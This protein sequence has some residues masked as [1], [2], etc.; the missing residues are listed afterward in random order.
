[1]NVNKWLSQTLAVLRKEL[2]DSVRDR[3]SLASGLLFSIFGPVLVAM[4]LGTLAKSL[5]SDKPLE[6]G[7]IGGERAPNLIA[8]LEQRDVRVHK[9]SGDA[10]QALR[11]GKEPVV[12]DIAADY[13]DDFRALRPAGL[14]LVHD[15]STPAGGRAMQRLQRQLEGFARETARWRLLARGVDPAIV[16]PLQIQPFDISTAMARA[17]RVLGSLP[18]FFLI[19]AFIGGMNVAIDTTAGERERGSLESLLCHSVPAS[20]LAMGKWLAASLFA[21]LSI[22][23]TLF[24][25]VQVFARASFEGL[26]VTIRFGAAEALGVFLVMVPLGLLV[27]AVQMLISIHAKNFKEAQTQLSLLMMLPMIPGFLLIAGALEKKPWMFFVPVLG[28]QI[29]IFDLLGGE[30]IPATAYVA[31]TLTTLGLSALFVF[32]L[33]RLFGN[34]KIVLAR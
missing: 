14:R 1:M 32:L 33:A 2:V 3:R 7:V 17:S 13:S 25:S 11:A 31:G 30:A 9:K 16:F 8:Y 19:A 23:L 18:I 12:L 21:L 5:G 24:M 20:A 6:I 15:S 10:Q 22:A 28:Q 29:G 34:E 4:L 27:P 26:G